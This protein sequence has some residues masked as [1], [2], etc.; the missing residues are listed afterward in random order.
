MNRKE[1]KKAYD[2]GIITEEQFKNELFKM[3]NKPKE[4]KK[5]KPLPISID[6]LEF[7][8]LIKHTKKEKFK[9]AFL[10]GYGAG[11]RLSEI[12]GGSRAEGIDIKPLTKDKMNF[13]NKSIFIEDAKGGKDRTVP[14]PK[15]LKE[16]YLKYLPLNQGYSTIESARRSME[17][18]FRLSAEKA[19]ILK[20]KPKLHF[21]S[22]RHGFGTQLANKGVPIHHIRTLMGHS[23]IST[24]NVY[25]EMNPKEALKSYEDLF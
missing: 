18:T 24:T 15:G 5:S 13:N 23:N 1:L 19:G 22:L 6:E 17:K 14:I 4:R 25:L 20:N 7:S 2:D 12:V 9:L 11:M 3:E 10:L 8:N 16:S 21:H